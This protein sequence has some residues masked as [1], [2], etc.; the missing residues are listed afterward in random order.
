M[1]DVGAHETCGEPTAIEEESFAQ[2]EE[3]GLEVDRCAPICRRAVV[4]QLSD[5]LSETASDVGKRVAPFD[6]RQDGGIEEVA[7][8]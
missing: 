6:A 3:A 1:Q 8:E 7:G 4:G 5:V 2:R